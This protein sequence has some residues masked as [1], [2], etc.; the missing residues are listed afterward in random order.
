MRVASSLHLA[1]GT[2]ARISLALGIRELT[3]LPQVIQ[4]KSSSHVHLLYTFFA[5]S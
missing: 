4:K 5:I 2:D 3:M 1:V